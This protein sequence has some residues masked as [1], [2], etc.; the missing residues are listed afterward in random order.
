MQFLEFDN[1][2]IKLNLLDMM[3]SDQITQIFWSEIDNWWQN[4]EAPVFKLWW[5]HR[6]LLSQKV[7]CLK[8]SCFYMSSFLIVTCYQKKHFGVQ[9]EAHP[10]IRRFVVDSQGFN[11]SVSSVKTLNSTLPLVWVWLV[12]AEETCCRK[13]TLCD[14]LC[15]KAKKML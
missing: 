10:A 11:V 9:M 4:L 7:M 8:H 13:S 3:C 1:V 2:L 15:R 6:P 14:V 5:L 12:T